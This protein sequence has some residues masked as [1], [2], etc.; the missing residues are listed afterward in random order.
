[1]NKKLLTTLLLCIFTFEPICWA[2]EVIVG[3]DGQARYV[4]QET[5]VIKKQEQLNLEKAK[6]SNSNKESSNTTTNQT[7][8]AST[9]DALLQKIE[10]T[11]G[12]DSYSYEEAIKLD[13]KYK[14]I[15]AKTSKTYTFK[16]S[17]VITQDMKNVVRA[18]LSGGNYVLWLPTN[19][20]EQFATEY[21]SDGSL[22]GF[23]KI[24]LGSSP[25]V[26][27]EYRV[28]SPN[29]L[30]GKLTHVMLCDNFE[31][32]LFIYTAEAKLRTA[33]FSYRYVSDGLCP[34]VLSPNPKFDRS[35]SDSIWNF[36][37]GDDYAGASA[38]MAY[39]AFSLLTLAPIMLVGA[40]LSPVLV[41]IT[42][43]L[44]PSHRKDAKVVKDLDN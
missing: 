16:K 29:D 31:K 40:I 15:I 3:V 32:T 33:S 24:N 25:R 43:P 14:N 7:V 42:S 36:F 26:Y 41:L 28:T 23:V 35:I 6:M 39:T 8:M 5:P 21:N 22:M 17:N 1:M 19:K 38:A 44:Q 37:W 4:N 13:K 20:S 12:R 30:Q 2:E 18:D 10:E 11:D 27:Y 9:M 34:P